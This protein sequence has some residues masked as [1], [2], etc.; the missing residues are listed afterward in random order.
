MTDSARAHLDNYLEGWKQ[1]DGKKS[2]E[3]TAPGFFY[4]DPNSSRVSRENFV[5]FV[6]EFK[7]AAA[8]LNQGIV[9]EPFLE[10]SD[11]LIGEGIA[12]CWWCV[13]G[14]EFQGSAVIHFGD[15]GVRSEK[16]AY[17]SALPD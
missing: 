15:D 10:Y 2:L 16:I 14:T 5:R 11:V 7:S 4:D 17:F 8:E 1:G 12:W 13:S 3:S 6:D 9:P